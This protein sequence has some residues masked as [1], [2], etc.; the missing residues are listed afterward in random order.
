LCAF[1]EKNI[2]VYPLYLTLVWLPNRQPTIIKVV[3]RVHNHGSEKL[4]K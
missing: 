4:K 1:I 2:D 3:L